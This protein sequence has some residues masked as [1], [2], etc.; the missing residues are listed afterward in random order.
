MLKNVGIDIK[1]GRVKLEI[2]S[3]A[4]LANNFVD[5]NSFTSKLST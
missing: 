3:A 1:G 4:F 5:I 2:N